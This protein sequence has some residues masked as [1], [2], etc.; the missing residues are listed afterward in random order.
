MKGSTVY[1][2][3]FGKCE[4]LKVQGNVITILDEADE[5]HKVQPIELSKEPTPAAIQAASQV[6]ADSA[7]EQASASG[8]ESWDDWSDEE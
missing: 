6:K 8:D 2:N 1:H 7:A 5:P 3:V 4:V